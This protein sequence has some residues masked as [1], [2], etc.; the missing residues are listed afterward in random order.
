[1]RN[2]VQLRSKRDSLFLLLGI[3]FVL[4]FAL[5]ASV[6][7]ATPLSGISSTAVKTLDTGWTYENGDELSAIGQLP[8]SIDFSGDTLYL[9]H[10]LANLSQDTGDV[11]TFRT[12]YE[13]I[14]VWADETLIYEAAQ[15]KEHALGSMWHFV[16]FDRCAGASDLRVGITKYNQDTNWE[17]STVLLDHPDAVQVHLLYTYAPAILFW[18]FSM[19]F[20][21]LL[22]FVAI[23][24]FQEKI[25]GTSTILVLSAFSFFPVNGFCWIPRLPHCSAA[26][27]H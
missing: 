12:R 3:F 22:F 13:S 18:I 11:L 9:H 19:L 2:F 24:M 20:A 27:M 15:G 7:F 14:R 25:P 16:P 17:L 6:C 26:I 4:F 8:R 1:M 21:L 5:L 10:D 23:F